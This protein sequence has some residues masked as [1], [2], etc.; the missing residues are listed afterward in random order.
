MH[1]LLSR[2]LRR[3][4]LDAA[5]PP[6]SVQWRKV[7]DKISQTYAQ[8][9]EERYL[10]ERSLRIAVDETRSLYEQLK[11]SSQAR[12]KAIA[13]AFPDFL[14]FQDEDGRFLDVFTS[15]PE[16]LFAS[17]EQI[18]GHRLEELFPP[19]WAQMFRKHLAATLEKAEMRQL[20]YHMTVMGERRLYEAR[21]V[22]MEY[23]SHGKRTLLTVVR[24]ITE[25]RRAETRANLVSKAVSAA[26]EGVVIL[27]EDYQVISANPALENICLV[28][29]EDILGQDPMFL[30]GNNKKV[31]E[32]RVWPI[33]ETSGG[34]Y[35]ELDVIRG[36]GS[37]A[38]LR[39]SIDKVLLREEGE[40]YYVILLSDISELNASKRELQ[41]LATHDP[42]TG[43]P[44]RLLFNDRL[45]QAIVRARRDNHFVVLLFMDLDRFKLINDSLGHQVGDQLLK[46]VA[47]RLQQN[48]R[49]TD[50]LARLGGDE[51]TLIIEDVKRPED[52]IVL[53]EKLQLALRKPYS[54][55]GYDISSTMSIGVSVYPK[56]G[57]S[58][59]E[60]F[61]HA[62]T[63]LY[64]AKDSGRDQYRFF[65]QKL[66]LSASS[67]F[68]TE[69]GL[70]QALPRNELYLLYQ[71][72]FALS[73]RKMVGVEALLRWNS[74]QLGEVSPLNFI[75]VAE[76]TGLIDSIGK[77]VLETACR[78]IADWREQGFGLSR[79]AIN[80]SS[81]ELLQPELNAQVAAILAKY[82][83][84]AECLE[85]EI[86]ESVIIER[87]DVAYQNLYALTDMGIELAIDDFGTGHS[88]LVNLKRF[89]LARLKIDR[90]FVRDVGLDSNDE[91]IIRATIALAQSFGM[92]TIAEG[93]ENE[94]QLE[95]LRELGCDEVQGFLF[96]KPITADEVV[97][98]NRSSQLSA[99][100]V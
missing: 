65:T 60:L 37:S 13:A 88:S 55:A 12:L 40:H 73:T 15:R 96:A 51:F 74:P 41:H 3:L 38:M 83:V 87:G 11:N 36:D 46:A 25:S 84:P 28:S 97:T 22:P 92:D 57:A 78:Q 75:P 6:D 4:G 62:D 31:L 50:T 77:W 69:Q 82:R 80:M 71:P 48:I 17:V 34:W 63:A 2:Q 45:Q 76:A 93:V 68:N 35:G 21:T 70:R 30:C 23:R 26:R 27:N 44:N 47:Q 67:Y 52:V 95:F 59:D 100:P 8:S 89:P 99:S 32:E 18:K 90:T 29:V 39:V 86:T 72:Q 58:L 19:E 20:E 10:L 66:V 81:R 56:D 54:V 42:L 98:L 24:D 61:K 9:D 16:D 43:L 14:F 53:L 91:A 64:A 33:V 5:I 85:I 7:L 49:E 1:A 94:V 79:V